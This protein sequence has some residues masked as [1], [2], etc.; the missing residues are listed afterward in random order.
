MVIERAPFLAELIRL[1]GEATAGPGR[2]VFVGGEAGAG[3]TTLIETFS[4][5]LGERVRVAIGA[6]DPLSTPRPLGPLLDM[7][8]ALGGLDALPEGSGSRDEL[9]R[10][11]LAKFGGG[12]PPTVVV[13]EDVHW[14]DEATIDLLRFLGRRMGASRGLL[15]ATYRDDEVGTRHPLRV[16]LGDLATLGAV[17]R[18]SLP[19]LPASAVAQLSEGSG[20]DVVTLHRQT[21]GNPFFVTEILAAGGEAIPATVRDVVLARAA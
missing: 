12:A 15:I 3:K 9:F 10:A 6:C 8:G 20:L 5:D 18:M 13:F 11:L 21:G 1:L 14:A 19:L 2:L 4:R 7:A 17:R 16:L